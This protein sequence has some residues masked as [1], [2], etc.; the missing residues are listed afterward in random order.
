MNFYNMLLL[1]GKELRTINNCR[2]LLKSKY[3]KSQTLR[4][5]LDQSRELP[6]SHTCVVV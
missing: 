3:P 2:V 5:K 6:G 1:N 4:I